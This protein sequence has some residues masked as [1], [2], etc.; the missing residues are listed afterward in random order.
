MENIK[1]EGMEELEIECEELE[2][3]PGFL[4]IAEDWVEPNYFD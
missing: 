2:F 1:N 4:G 3:E